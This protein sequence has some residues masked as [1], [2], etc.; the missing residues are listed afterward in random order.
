MREVPG[1][2][3]KEVCT[4]L[5]RVGLYFYRLHLLPHQ[6]DIPLLSKMEPQKCLP[7]PPKS[8]GLV[9]SKDLKRGNV[10]VMRRHGWLSHT[11]RGFMVLNVHHRFTFPSDFLLFNIP[12]LQLALSPRWNKA[13]GQSSG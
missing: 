6:L 8:Q 4:V 9:T 5:L 3:K 7:S 1:C 10:N 12:T 11:L 2:T 13:N